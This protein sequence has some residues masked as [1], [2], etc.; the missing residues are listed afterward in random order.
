MFYRG[1]KVFIQS[2]SIG[3][4]LQRCLDRQ[5]LDLEKPWEVWDVYRKGDR[6]HKGI[7]MKP[8]YRVAINEDIIVVEGDFFLL[9]DLTPAFKIDNTSFLGRVTET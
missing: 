7:V 2:K 3:D 5:D 9:Q 4:S 1:D 8:E 6:D